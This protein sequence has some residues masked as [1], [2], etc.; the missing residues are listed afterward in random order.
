MKIYTLACIL[1]GAA[2]HRMIIEIVIGS[3]GIGETVLF[4][5]IMLIVAHKSL[6]ILRR[7]GRYYRAK[8]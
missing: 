5:A 4:V 1:I 8:S 6:S 2:M 7:E 3:S